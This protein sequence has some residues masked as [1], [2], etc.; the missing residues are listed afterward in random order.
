MYCN[1]KLIQVARWRL[2]QLKTH[3]Q[4]IFSTTQSPPPW[5]QMI[6]CA[7]ATTLPLVVAAALNHHVPPG[8]ILGSLLGYFLALNDHLGTITH[9]LAVTAISF[10]A[11]ILMFC[12]GLALKDQFWMF[13][14]A[15]IFLTYWL[16][17]L[18]GT[19]A[20]F[21]RLLLF[22]FVG[23][24]VAY[25]TPTLVGEQ[26][27][28]TFH[29]SLLAFATT[30]AGMIFTQ[31]LPFYKM[32]R[33]FARIRPSFANSFTT[34]RSRHLYAVTYLTATLIAV[35]VYERFSIERGYWTV[36]TVLLVMRPDHKESVYRGVQRLIGTLSGVLV[37]EEIILHLPKVEWL[38]LGIMISA[39][40]IPYVMKRTYIGVSLLVS[41]VVMLLLTIPTIEHPDPHI[42]YV[43]LAATL[44]G[45]L[46]SIVGVS[47]A[48]L[49][50]RRFA[51]ANQAPG[52]T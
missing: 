43:R 22:S 42:P 5:P 1:K 13:L 14:G 34:L 19:G 47:I 49:A 36:I 37:G 17:V 11:M 39:F 7:L 6:V 35:F 31:Q 27:S 25:Y 3:A 26:F 15:T 45:C 10:L 16:G 24:L 30:V 44:Y 28:A 9:R 8:A 20:E 48:S 38:I 41:V 29:Y 32:N 40:L 4:T 46:I 12:L 33:A 2:R 51:R 23:F 21:E 52:C 50:T 18:G